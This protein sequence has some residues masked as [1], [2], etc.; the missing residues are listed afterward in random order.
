M[1]SL[2]ASLE[3]VTTLRLSFDLLLSTH[4]SH[5]LT[6]R[7]SSD[8]RANRANFADKTLYSGRVGLGRSLHTSSCLGKD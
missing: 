1:R 7:S 3:L 8:K 2:T 5:E 6:K 4:G